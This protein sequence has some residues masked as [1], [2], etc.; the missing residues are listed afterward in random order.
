[1]I[2]GSSPR[3]MP[4]KNARLICV[5]MGNDVLMSDFRPRRLELVKRDL[6]ESGIGIKQMRVGVNTQQRCV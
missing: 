2:C 5:T 3:H 4:L 1:M 6:V